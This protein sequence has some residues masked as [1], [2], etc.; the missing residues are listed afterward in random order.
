MEISNNNRIRI[1][2]LHMYFVLSDLPKF[3]QYLYLPSTHR[4]TAMH[5]SPSSVHVA[6]YVA[7]AQ[8]HRKETKL[9]LKAYIAC[10]MM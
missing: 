4:L 7:Q 6:I 2:L 9:E 8:L 3:T 5:E 1:R 10:N